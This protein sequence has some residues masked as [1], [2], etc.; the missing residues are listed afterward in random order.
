VVLPLLGGVPV[1]GPVRRAR[2]AWAGSLL[3]RVVSITVVLSLAVVV[4]IGTVLV[5]RIRD[6]LIDARVDSAVAEAAAGAESAVQLADSTD[7]IESQQAAQLVDQIAVALATRAG[8]PALYDV[9]LLASPGTVAAPQRGSAAADERSV[10]AELRTTV[11]ETGQ[12][13]W[14]FTSIVEPDGSTEPGIVVGAPL[15]ISGVGAYEIYFLFPLTSQEATLDLV[16]NGILIAGLVLVALLGVIAWFVT[17]SV[18][19]PVRSASMVAER[20]AAGR[21][22]ERM[23]VRGE[24]EFARLAAAFNAMA[25]NIKRQIRQLEDLSRV[26]RRFVADVSHE[27]RTPITTIRMAA[28]VIH[29][30]RAELDGPTRRASELLIEQLDRFEDLLTDLLE[31]SRFDAGS[32]ILDAD[33]IDLRTTVH[34]VIDSAAPL[35]E[36]KGIALR[37]A[38]PAD[39]VAV[40]VDSIR[41]ERVLRNLVVNAIEHGEGRPVEVTVAADGVAAAV[42]VRDHGVGLRP[43]ESSLVFNRFW[44]SDPSRAR[45]TGG[46]GLG[47]S[48]ALEDARL[49]GGWLE[50]WGEPGTGSV[51]RL[52]LPRRAGASIAASPLPLRPAEAL[53][54]PVAEAVPPA[55]S[56]DAGR[57]PSPASMPSQGAG[58]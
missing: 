5:Q 41:I 52:T 42:T 17:R 43:G 49:H 44:R 15:S 40:E 7:R 3:V 9:L 10:P 1:P 2:D 31:I 11:Q 19:Q 32:A 14:T 29:T 35:A 37:I 57:R 45:T 34:R 4:L 8:D 28:D 13:A 56:D 39:P 48:I 54:D 6:G 51:F 58:P 20:L 50:A 46:T 22:E 38:E 30:H 23:Q 16:R 27:L 18:V 12:L 36:A 47:L 21:L 25:A 33:T 24:D 55:V 26:Q 53:E